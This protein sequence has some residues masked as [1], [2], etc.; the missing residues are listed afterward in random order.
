[1][2]EEAIRLWGW[3]DPDHPDPVAGLP[4]VEAWLAARL[5]LERLPATPPVAL[6]P[7]RVPKSKLTQ[8]MRTALAAALADGVFSDDRAVRALHTLGQ[9]Y[10]DQ[11]QRRAGRIARTV[12]AVAFPENAAEA[13]AVLAAAAKSG[14][15]VVPR[16]GG[17]SVVGGLSAPAGDNRPVVALDLSRM[18]RVLELSKQDQTVTAEAGI[19][20]ADLD[21]ALKPEWLTLGHEPQSFHAVT[22]GGA[23][24][25]AGSGQRSDRYGPVGENL[26]SARIATPS[27]LWSTERFRHAAT[28]PWLGGLAIGSE[29]AFGIITDATMRLHARPEHVEDRAWLLPSFA[30]AAAAVRELA[31]QG[32]ALA[33]LR[34]SDEAETDFLGGYR[35]AR[36]GLD[37]PGS[38]ERMLLKVKGAPKRAALL[39]A[40]YEG[41]NQG[42]AYAYAT[43]KRVLARHGAVGVGGRPGQSWR[44]GRFEGPHLRESLMARGLGVDTFETAVPWSAV[45]TVHAAVGAALARAIAAT[46]PGKGRPAVFCHLSHSYIEGACLYFTAIFP[47]ADD[48]LEQWRTIKQAA[49]DAMVEHGGTVSHHHGVG[50][51]HA[52]WVARANGPLEIKL[53]EAIRRELDPKDVM[54]PGIRAAFP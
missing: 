48:A 12:D 51:D 45:E 42:T 36:A 30:D 5:G 4:E 21:A 27:G 46:L 41:A 16:G 32:H 26:V 29:G 34:V 1:M 15:R 3:L 19:R 44:K 22:L 2:A 53:M 10:P 14:F 35:L 18:N 24:A 9:S 47:R 50:A 31:Q 7:A 6:D 33:M 8:R 20:L 54:A 40:G 37:R 13:A 25:A 52:A 17:S 49:T 39:I 11:L 28:G 23:L 38:L 43:A